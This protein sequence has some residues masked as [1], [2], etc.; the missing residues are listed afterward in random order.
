MH[1]RQDEEINISLNCVAKDK[2][3]RAKRNGSGKKSRGRVKAETKRKGQGQDRIG[4]DRKKGELN[5]M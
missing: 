1:W 5:S 3:D 4:E 2:T